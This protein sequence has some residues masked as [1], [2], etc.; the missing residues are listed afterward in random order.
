[1]LPPAE[2][3]RASSS[4]RPAGQGLRSATYRST[5]PYF[6][7]LYSRA[8]PQYDSGT[9]ESSGPGLS[10][11]PQHRGRLRRKQT[12]THGGRARPRCRRPPGAEA[13]PPA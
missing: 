11:P 8:H 3:L 2:R 7:V 9:P 6:H 10:A 13:S 5:Q 12:R 4:R 1:M